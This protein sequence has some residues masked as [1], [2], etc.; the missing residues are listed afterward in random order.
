[1]RYGL[2]NDE[3]KQITAQVMQKSV[4]AI[5]QTHTYNFAQKFFLQKRGGPIEL[6]STCCVARLVMMWWDQEFLEV[7]KKSNLTILGGARYMDDVRVWLAA[8][9]LG[10]RWVNG[11][12]AYKRAWML[13]EKEMGMT[14]LCKTTEV[15]QGMMNSICSWLVLTMETEEMFRDKKLPTLDVKIWVE[16]EDNINRILFIFFEKEMVSPMVLHKR[17]AMRE[18]IRR[19]TL[20]Q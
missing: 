7:V 3:K 11:R 14:G 12:L 4:L 5:F 10:W 13:E 20:N 17:S 15:L 8:V 19:D 16:V 1:M 18:G 2:T 9:R 6:R